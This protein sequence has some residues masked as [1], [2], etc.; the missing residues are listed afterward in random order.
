MLVH[1]R[2]T[3]YNGAVLQK[4]TTKEENMDEQVESRSEILAGIETFVARYPF[5]LDTFQLEAIAQL[6][7]GQSVMVAAPTGTGKTLV[8]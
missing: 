6:A 3:C 7:Q 4:L 8:A 5:P 1:P 2:F